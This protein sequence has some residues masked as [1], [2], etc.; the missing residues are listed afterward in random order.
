M[1]P[2]MDEVY[3]GEVADL[4]PKASPAVPSEAAE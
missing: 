3:R 1:T 2:R 4:P